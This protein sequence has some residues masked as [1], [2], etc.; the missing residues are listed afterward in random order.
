MSKIW[1]PL[2]GRQPT[3]CFKVQHGQTEKD[4]LSDSD[5]GNVNYDS[6]NIP[7]DSVQQKQKSQAFTFVN[8]FPTNMQCKNRSIQKDD[9]SDRYWS[10]S[11]SDV[12]RWIQEGESLWPWWVRNF[13][14]RV[15]PWQK[16]HECIGWRTI[17]QYG[18][19]AIYSHW[20]K[21][22][23]KPIFHTV[24][25]KGSILLRLTT[26]RKMGK[27]QKH[28]RVFHWSNRHPTSSNKNPGQVWIMQGWGC[29]SY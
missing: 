7:V 23:I 27:F 22:F 15:Q 4:I 19:R 6:K 21:L 14:C 11:K 12:T 24:E 9:M 29:V 10:R 1:E 26:L 5:M 13:S 2:T 20:D 16:N 8:K 18:V 25:A 3:R 17:K 28:P